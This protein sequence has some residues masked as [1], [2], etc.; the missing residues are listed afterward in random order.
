MKPLL[1]LLISLQNTHSTINWTIT[2]LN[3]YATYTFEIR[4][5]LGPTRGLWSEWTWIEGTTDEEGG[6]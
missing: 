6:D 4:W 2:S 1:T 3:P 5:K